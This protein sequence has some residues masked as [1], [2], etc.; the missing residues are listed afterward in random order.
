MTWEP[1]W[2]VS[3][4]K[5][6]SNLEWMAI[7][8]STCQTFRHLIGVGILRVHKVIKVMLQKWMFRMFQAGRTDNDGNDA[9]DTAADFGGRRSTDDVNATGRHERQACDFWFP[10]VRRV[11]TGVFSLF[12]VLLLTQPFDVLVGSPSQA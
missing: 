1:C 9:V 11:Y 6:R 8:S 3:I 2:T 10:L 7:F 12:P 5:F 4:N